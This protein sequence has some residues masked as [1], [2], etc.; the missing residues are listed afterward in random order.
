[1]VTAALK[2]F[3]E[4]MK[5]LNRYQ[6]AG[7]VFLVL[8]TPG[9]KNI[10]TLFSETLSHFEIFD[11]LLR[12]ILM[13]AVL[14]ELSL[15][16]YALLAGP[17]QGMLA[18]ILVSLIT[19]T[20]IGLLFLLTATLEAKAY[21]I[22][23]YRQRSVYEAIKHASRE[24]SLYLG[25]LR[26]SSRL[27][28]GLPGNVH[29]PLDG[30]MILGCLSDLV[31]LSDLNPQNLESYENFNRYR[32]YHQ[33]DELEKSSTLLGMAYGSIT[34]TLWSQNRKVS[35]LTGTLSPTKAPRVTRSDSGSLFYEF[36]L[37]GQ[38]IQSK[39]LPALLMV[40]I[41]DLTY[42]GLILAAMVTL[43]AGQVLMDYRKENLINP[44]SDSWRH[45]KQHLEPFIK[46]VFLDRKLTLSA[47]DKTL[48]KTLKHDF[49]NQRP[50]SLRKLHKAQR[51]I[52]KMASNDNNRDFI[53]ELLFFTYWEHETGA[54]VN[55]RV[56][57]RGLFTS[58]PVETVLGGVEEFSSSTDRPIELETS[59][60]PVTTEQTESSIPS[61][62]PDAVDETVADEDAQARDRDFIDHVSS[63]DSEDIGQDKLPDETDSDELADPQNN[64]D[65]DQDSD[66]PVASDESTLDP[67]SSDSEA[68]STSI[69]DPGENLELP[70]ALP[71]DFDE[72]EFVAGDEEEYPDE[73]DLPG[74]VN[75]DGGEDSIDDL[76]DS[77]LSELGID[78]D[79]QDD[80]P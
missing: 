39:L 54:E 45:L 66:T 64:P 33:Y 67:E 18:N 69:D 8:L 32:Q 63:Q 44:G 30:I 2:L 21:V 70:P 68:V 15:I 59:A 4:S 79:L 53:H 47:D 43:M 38:S 36:F 13:P 71:D 28:T 49:Q 19:V 65:S 27:L 75:L 62:E 73:D 3:L 7:L 51:I 55:S 78:I 46:A 74:P 22:T 56:L 14:V 25:R 76:L 37:H 10:R 80:K 57:R 1:M 12:R 48:L 11:K 72:D 17:V 77:R 16:S 5:D 58:A 6:Q 61:E 9:S 29:R 52:V 26:D 24:P 35:A 34:E 40:M 60:A 31:E 23:T 20:S 41:F 42:A 50:L